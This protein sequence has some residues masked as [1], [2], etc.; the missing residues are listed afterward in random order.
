MIKKEKINL[1]QITDPVYERLCK[2]FDGNLNISK[3]VNKSVNKILNR[4][5]R[6][7][8]EEKDKNSVVA[9]PSVEK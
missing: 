4:L 1:I 2:R 3:F 8:Q 5:D 9:Q 7:E 6:L